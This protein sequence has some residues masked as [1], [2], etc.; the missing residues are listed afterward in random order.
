MLPSYG[1]CSF[2]RKQTN[3]ALIVRAQLLLNAFS[4]GEH[5]LIRLWTKLSINLKI[6]YVVASFFPRSINFINVEHALLLW[7][8][9]Y[10][11][12]TNQRL[13][14][15]SANKIKCIFC[16]IV[17]SFILNIYQGCSSIQVFDSQSDHYIFFSVLV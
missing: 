14:L 5:F 7:R 15:L 3:K 12:D 10:T 11:G 9:N 4:N 16:C 2:D 17:F 6:L 1:T 8:Q 13:Q